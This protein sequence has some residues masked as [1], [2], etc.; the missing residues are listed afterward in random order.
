MENKN[1]KPKSHRVWAAWIICSVCLSLGCGLIVG[2][3]DTFL[4]GNWLKYV[5][6]KPDLGDKEERLK[7]LASVKEDLKRLQQELKQRAQARKPARIDRQDKPS[8][9]RF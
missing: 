4:S 9:Y 2:L 8:E 5:V 3:S 6:G 1:K 7:S